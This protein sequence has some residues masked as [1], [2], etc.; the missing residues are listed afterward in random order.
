[1]RFRSRVRLP[2]A[3]CPNDGLGLLLL[4]KAVAL[5]EA[6][7]AARR[8]HDAVF[9]GEEGMTVAAYLD[10]Q[11]R[12]GGAGLEGVPAGADDGR[13]YVFWMDVRFHGRPQLLLGA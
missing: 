6:L 3:F 2:F 9:A 1:V 11:T 13:F 12:L 4:L 8:V 5:E 7:H 10:V